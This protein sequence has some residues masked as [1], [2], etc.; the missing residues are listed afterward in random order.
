M[1]SKRDLI[2]MDEPTSNMDIESKQRLM[3]KIIEM[4]QGILMIS[5]DKEV[6]EDSDK[7]FYMKN[8]MVVDQGNFE[9]LSSRNENFAKEIVTI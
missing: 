4:E 1:A 3:K 6:L 5:H 9:E 2:F 7:I 8:G